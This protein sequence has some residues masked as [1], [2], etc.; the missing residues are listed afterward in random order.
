[1]PVFFFFHPT[2]PKNDQADKATQMLADSLLSH[3]LE[4]A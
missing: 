2:F 1:M 4:L 3:S